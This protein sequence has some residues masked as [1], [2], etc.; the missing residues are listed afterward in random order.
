[1][2]DHLTQLNEAAFL[3]INATE[4]SPLIQVGFALIA[5]KALVLLVPMDLMRRW[6]GR[7]RFRSR[8]VVVASVLALSMALAASWVIGTLFSTPRPF[9]AGIGHTLMAHR[10][11]PSFPSNHGIIFATHT[12]VLW[13]FGHR[14]AAAAFLLLGISVGWARIYLGV[15]FPADMLGSVLLACAAAATAY[16]TCR[17]AV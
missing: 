4:Q 2:G 10:P 17:R 5:A 1:M 6:F 9:L 14:I 7:G 13:L 16:L 15:H 8:R 12:A 11:S 3:L